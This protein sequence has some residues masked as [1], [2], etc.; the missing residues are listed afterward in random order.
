MAISKVKQ[1]IKR[2]GAPELTAHEIAIIKEHHEYHE[3]KEIRIIG[4]LPKNAVFVKVKDR[5]GH[6]DSVIDSICYKDDCS[7]DS[8]IRDASEEKE[9][10]FIKK[11]LK[12]NLSDDEF[13][14]LTKEK[15]L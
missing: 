1:F 5:L 3:D 12:E 7:E 9:I 10:A 14:R 6:Y 2:L 4:S 15:K 8:F 11:W 13:Q